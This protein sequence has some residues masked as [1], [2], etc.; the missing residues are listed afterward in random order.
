MTQDVIVNL[1]KSP[2][3]LW[4]TLEHDNTMGNDVGLET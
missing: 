4:E 1:V 2:Q 3:R